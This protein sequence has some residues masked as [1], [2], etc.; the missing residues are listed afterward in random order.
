[1]HIA[2]QY[3]I[4]QVYG[5]TFK[6][7]P[8]F[9]GNIGCHYYHLGVSMRQNRDFIHYPLSLIHIYDGSI[10]LANSLWIS[11]QLK[12]KK[13]YREMAAARFFASSYQVDFTSREAGQQ[14]GNWI[15]QETNGVMQ[16]ELQ[17]PSDTMMAILNLSLI[18]I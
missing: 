10:E 13:D 15:S 14:I 3:V 2:L 9:R 1:M 4:L 12:L 16:P 8:Y 5:K 17:L 11:N 6:F 7:V 18:H